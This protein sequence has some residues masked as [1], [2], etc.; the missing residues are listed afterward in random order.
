MILSK[1]WPLVLFALACAP[2]PVSEGCSP[3][4]TYD[5]TI[6]N[7]TTS[8]SDEVP[9]TTVG[10]Q[11]HDNLTIANLDGHLLVNPIPAPKNVWSGG[12]YFA[13]TYGVAGY[14]TD[15]D[16]HLQTIETFYDGPYPVITLNYTRD[17]AVAGSAV[18]GTI[19]VTMS[20]GSDAIYG[21]GGAASCTF[22]GTAQG[23]LTP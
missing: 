23:T 18:T 15:C 11:W 3:F 6:T 13:T 4:G 22:P 14:F 12:V 16:L 19:L 5:V 17:Y 2:K 10:E 9:C 7:T 1:L 21:A 20:A 8:P